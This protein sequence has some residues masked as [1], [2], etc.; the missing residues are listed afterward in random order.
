MIKS[1]LIKMWL[2]YL[3]NPNTD[4]TASD[5]IKYCYKKESIYIS[6]TNVSQ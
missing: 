4:F 3:A 1:F 5:A 6:D 2:S